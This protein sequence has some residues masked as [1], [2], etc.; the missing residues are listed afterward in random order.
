[1]TAC[2]TE[3][4]IPLFIR[5]ISTG[6]PLG[7]ARTIFEQNILGGMCA[8]VCPTETLCEQACVR[9]TAEDR[10]VDIG[11]LQRY[12]TDIAMEQG[13]QFFHRGQPPA[14][15][16][17]S[18]ARARRPRLRP[19]ACHERPYRHY[20]RRARKAGGLNEY[21]IATYKATDDF[22]QKEVDYLLA[23]GGIDIRNGQAL[24]RDFR[25][26]IWLPITMP[27]F[28]GSVLRASTVSASKAKTGR[29]R[30]RGG[31]HR[32]SASG[33][34][35]GGCADRPSRRGSRRRHD[36]CDAA[37]QAKLLGAEEVTICYRRGKEHMN[38]SEFEQDLAASKGV[39]IRHWLAPK[40]ILG[41]EVR[42]RHRVGIYRLR[43]GHLV[44]T[45]ETGVIAATRSSRPS[46]SPS[47]Q[48]AWARWPWRKAVSSDRFRRGAWARCRR[49]HSFRLCRCRA[50]GCGCC[51]NPVEDEQWLIFAIISSASN[52]RTLLAGLCPADRQGLQRRARLQGGLG[53]RGVEDAGLRRPAR[54]Q[55]Q[56][57]ALR[58]NLGADR[59]LLGLN[60]IE[61]ITDRPLQINLQEM[62][63]VKMNW[64]DRA[65]VA[66]IMVPCVE[67]EW[68]AI[69]PLVEE[70]GADGIELN[71]GCPHG[72][73]ERGMG[74]AVG[75]VPEYIEMVVRWCKQY[76]RMPVITKLTPNITDI[77]NPARA[78]KRGGTDAVSLINTINSIT[79]VDLDNFA[80]V[81]SVDGK[82]SHGGYCGPAV[83]PIALNMVSEIARDPETYGLPISGIGGVT[84]WRD[85]AEFSSWG[86]QCTGLYR[87]HDLWLQDRSGNDLRPL[88]LDGREGPP[89]AG[90]HH[91]TRRANVTDW[92]Y[93]NLNYV[94]KPISI[95]MPASNAAAAT[96]PARIPRTKRSPAWSMV[97][98][99][100]SAPARW[101]NPPTPTGPRI[102]TTRWP[103]W[104]RSKRDQRR[105]WAGHGG[106]P[107]CFGI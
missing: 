10:P 40:R 20:L 101:W 24:G 18:S 46:A 93:L 27:V 98:D 88:R 75:Q 2:P 45:G 30:R 78:A 25:F 89:L 12:A 83:K 35:Q 59:R 76:T 104:P 105:D 97:S 36:R 41:K 28:L 13:R 72:M 17:L 8:R 34:Q 69:L 56:R 90:R 100:S 11:R 31:F 77:R 39:T 48:V 5:Q 94:A 9:N 58:R 92:K 44:G 52:R 19:S 64:P 4:D 80:P 68:K 81:P 57:P 71:F 50:T 38:A 42:C 79:S 49:S 82:G 7:A 87:G 6:N 63:Q 29:R 85:A 107:I 32:L 106:A 67:E 37:V 62:K 21:G 65:L 73:S 61:L 84:T 95:R 74:S 54:R 23:I 99:T 103:R 70:T 22:A 55:R 1:M 33:G 26:R 91:R 66:S 16:L 47:R 60:N 102:R 53:R 3:I 86:W 15:R 51:L 43:D 14:R 96:S